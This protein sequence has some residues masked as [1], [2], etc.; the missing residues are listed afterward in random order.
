MAKKKLFKGKV[1]IVLE[2]LYG[3]IKVYEVFNDKD[4]QLVGEFLYPPSEYFD[5]H[6]Y[7]WEASGDDSD[8][9]RYEEIDLV[10]LCHLLLPIT[11][12]HS[13]QYEKI[14]LIWDT[15]DDYRSYYRI[16]GE[17]EE[18]DDEFQIRLDA[19]E[20]EEKEKEQAKV[21]AA[22]KKLERKR[23]MLEKLK[24]ELDATEVAEVV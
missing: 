13:S 4:D 10:K 7:R 19:A 22:E 15:Y 20:K 1:Q 14:L 12:K 16:V 8:Y 24:K 21:I 3:K 5:W 18:T 11:A 6:R 23:A 2:T 9:V 17:R